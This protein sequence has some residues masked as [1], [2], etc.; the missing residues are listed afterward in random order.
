MTVKLKPNP[1]S[2]T[3]SHTAP[4]YIDNE[5]CGA[6][7]YSVDLTGVLTKDQAVE[8]GRRI[9]A[10]QERAVKKALLQGA[11]ILRRLDKPAGEG[12]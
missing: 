5:L 4:V 2:I 7:L 3:L 10:A 1:A 9:S 8:L 12:A 6:V 11:D